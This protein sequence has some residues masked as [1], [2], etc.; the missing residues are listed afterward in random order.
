MINDSIVNYYLMYSLNQTIEDELKLNAIEKEEA[1]SVI[2]QKYEGSDDRKTLIVE[3][4]DRILR[5]VYILSTFFFP[6]LK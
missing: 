5:R 2:Q 4:T 3:T 6:L 1:I